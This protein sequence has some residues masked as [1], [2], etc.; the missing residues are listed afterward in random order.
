MSRRPAP[1]RGLVRLARAGIFG[2]S[3]LLLATGAHLLG[4][5]SLPGAGVLLVAAVLL[6]LL[7]A[8]LTARR[9]RFGVVVGVLAV[10][11]LGLH[12]LFGLAA[13]ARTCALPVTGSHALHVVGASG[14]EPSASCATGAGMAMAMTAGGTPAWVMGAAHVVAVLATAWLLARGEAWLWRAVDRV[15][16]AAGLA[17][18]HPL[19]STSRDRELVGRVAATCRSAVRSAAAPRGPPLASA[20]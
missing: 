11:Q 16:S 5:G 18:S 17:G 4:G 10:Q 2:G 3:S 8:V 19:S 14:V 12:E 1:T 20:R 6:A 15:V 9:C 7:V 13:A